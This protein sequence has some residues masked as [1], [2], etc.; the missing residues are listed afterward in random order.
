[1]QTMGGSEDPLKSMIWR[2]WIA[3]ATH[4]RKWLRFMKA[5]G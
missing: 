4:T 5:D 3:G 1:M 2:G